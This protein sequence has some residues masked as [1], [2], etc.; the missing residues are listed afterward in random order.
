MGRFCNNLPSSSSQS[1]FVFSV[2]SYSVTVLRISV[3]LLEPGISPGD[4]S[5]CNL[6]LERR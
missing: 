1:V 2:P 4:P 5:Q 3:T 6:W